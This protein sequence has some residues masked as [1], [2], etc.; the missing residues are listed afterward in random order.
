MATLFNITTPVSSMTLDAQ[1]KG[2]AAFTVSNTSGHPLR[3]RARVVTQDTNILP[4][5]TVDAPTD[6]S[7]AAAGTEQYTVQIAVP[8]NAAAGD[9]TFRLL[10]VEETNPDENFTEG[11]GVKVTVPAPVE[12]PK[13]PFPWWIVAI[14]VAVLVIVVAAIALIVKANDDARANANATA[15]SQSATNAAQ[16]A[17]QAATSTA[18]VVTATARAAQTSTA[19]SLAVTRTALALACQPTTISQ[20]INPIVITFQLPFGLNGAQQSFSNINAAVKVSPIV[21]LCIVAHW[22]NVSFVCQAGTWKLL[23]MNAPSTS[24]GTCRASS[25]PPGVTVKGGF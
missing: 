24:S 4:W 22:D 16:A 6:R 1:R 14:A 23:N 8:P 15:T 13:K 11:P 20:T 12:E 19:Q 3:A 5:F 17:N 10:M 18:Q 9:Y 2:K 25:L 21:D 7:I